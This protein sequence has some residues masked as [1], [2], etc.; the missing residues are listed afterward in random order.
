M[1][2]KNIVSKLLLLFNSSLYVIG[3]NPQTV[4][5]SYVAKVEKGFLNLSNFEYGVSL[6][7]MSSCHVHKGCNHNALV[8]LD[9]LEVSKNKEAEALFL[10]K[11]NKS[12]F[13]TYQKSNS[14]Y[15]SE[16]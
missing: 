15:E 10:F 16:I 4:A 9:E 6:S 14:I 1:P 12:Y 11:K 13:V 8:I 2:E 7:D 3:F 5:N